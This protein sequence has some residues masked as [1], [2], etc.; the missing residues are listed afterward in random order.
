MTAFTT[1]FISPKV[2][3]LDILKIISLCSGA[4]IGCGKKTGRIRYDSEK[5]NHID[6][7]SVEIRQAGKIESQ[8][9]N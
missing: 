1:L 8:S 4:L 2:S 7:R 5:W 3:H 9:C 6:I